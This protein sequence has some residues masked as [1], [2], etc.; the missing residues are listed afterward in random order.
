MKFQTLNKT[1][2]TLNLQGLESKLL[3]NHQN[4][5]QKY[6]RMFKI[7]LIIKKT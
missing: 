4:K 5:S 2:K 7:Y 1:R 3:I 6:L